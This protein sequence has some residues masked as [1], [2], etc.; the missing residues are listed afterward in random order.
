[1]VAANLFS[2]T[3]NIQLGDG[4]AVALF[5]ESELNVLLESNTFKSNSAAVSLYQT[6]T[7]SLNSC[8]NSQG[9]AVLAADYASGS[10]AVFKNNTFTDNYASVVSEYHCVN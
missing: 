10:N 8:S 5:S 7:S 3:W 1:L 2:C 6:V 4:G 9:G